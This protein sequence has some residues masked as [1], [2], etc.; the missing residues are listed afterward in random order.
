MK[1]IRDQIFRQLAGKRFRAVLTVEQAGILAG[2]RMA[3]HQAKALGVELHLCKPEGGQLNHGE[4]IGTLT[5]EAKSIAMAEERI[6]G[7]LAKAS[8]IATAAHTAVLLAA[9]RSRIVSGSW[10]KMPPEIKEMVR[11]AVEVG[12][13]AYRI[14]EPPMLY[15]DKNYIRMLGSIP[16]ALEACAAFPDHTKVV[17]LRGE[18]KN[19]AQETREA[20][21]GGAH[22]LMVDTGCR[23]DLRSCL[24]E[25]EAMGARQRM[26]VAFAG[27]VKLTD[28]PELTGQADI[29]C[30]GKEIV[31]ARLLDWKLDVIGE[32]K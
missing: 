28:I 26:K 3:E 23:E 32:E 24:S 7:T 4:T 9:G 30:V 19:I 15:L 10:K 8:G 25:L 17:Q 21:Q 6:I 18:G 22:I 13:A 1:D 12:G 29:L 11:H 16:K 27:N 2:T 31:D 5:A 14:T 20:V